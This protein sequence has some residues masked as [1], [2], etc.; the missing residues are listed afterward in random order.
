MWAGCGA[1]G[2][3]RV[4]Y[5]RKRAGELPAERSQVV[6]AKGEYL[7]SVQSGVRTA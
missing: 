3:M 2:A 7:A 5:S 1:Y 4:M 6:Q